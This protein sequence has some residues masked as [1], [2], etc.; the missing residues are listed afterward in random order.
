MSIAMTNLI[1]CSMY[2]DI[3]SFGFITN[4]RLKKC[5]INVLLN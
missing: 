3:I 1:D 5:G 2:Y 4:K